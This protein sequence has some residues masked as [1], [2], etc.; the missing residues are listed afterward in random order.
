MKGMWLL[1]NNN[2]EK[3]ENKIG[4]ELGLELEP[5]IELDG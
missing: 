4:D 3:I 5:Y 1:L 2:K